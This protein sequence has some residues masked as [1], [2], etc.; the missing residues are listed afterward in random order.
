MPKALSEITKLKKKTEPASVGKDPGV[1]Y[2]PR[3]KG[4]QDFVSLHKVEKTDDANGN[5]DDVFSGSTK[6]SKDERHG[7]TPDPKAKNKYK[8]VNSNKKSEL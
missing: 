1:D 3:S 6:Q 8:E 7:H 2:A 4:E 5:D